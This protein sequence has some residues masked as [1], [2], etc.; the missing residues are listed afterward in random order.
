MHNYKNRSKLKPEHKFGN[1][2]TGQLN[3]GQL[4]G[5]L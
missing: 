2:L 1:K 3:G 4:Y 5:G